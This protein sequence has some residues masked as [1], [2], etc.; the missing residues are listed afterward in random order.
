MKVKIE[1]KEVD[2]EKLSL[3]I[4]FCYNLRIYS[5]LEAYPHMIF[6]TDETIVEVKTNPNK[7][8]KII[9]V[10]MELEKQ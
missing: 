9:R 3:L 4:S 6:Y 7:R 5:K 1:D 2:S 10:D 8:G